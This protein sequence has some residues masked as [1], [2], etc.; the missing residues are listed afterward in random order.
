MSRWLS[1]DEDLLHTHRMR[2]L[3]DAVVVGVDTVLNDDPQLTVRRCAGRNPVRVVIDP[4]G[5][6]TAASVCFAT[7]PRP[8]WCSPQPTARTPAPCAAG[9]PRSWRCRA[10]ADVL[11]PVAIRATCWRNGG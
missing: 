8:R 5:G 6:W 7:A 11:D 3:C 1:G 2:A 10:R 4:D 9:T